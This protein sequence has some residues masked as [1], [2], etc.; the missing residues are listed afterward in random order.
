M[1]G[2]SFIVVAAAELEDVDNATAAWLVFNVVVVEVVVV[3]F[4]GLFPLLFLSLL[5]V[6]V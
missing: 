3:F 1:Y 5:V 2:L 6:V 4:F